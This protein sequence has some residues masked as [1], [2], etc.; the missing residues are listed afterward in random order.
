MLAN[1]LHVRHI[2][3]YFQSLL[4][5]RPWDFMLIWYGVMHI[6][7]QKWIWQGFNWQFGSQTPTLKLGDEL[8]EMLIVVKHINY[9]KLPDGACEH[10]SHLIHLQ[11][12]GWTWKI[13]SSVSCLLQICV[14]FSAVWW[15][16]RSICFWMPYVIKILEHEIVTIWNHTNFEVWMAANFTACILHFT[17]QT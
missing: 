4:Y 16:G 2:Y 14:C 8:L 7:K 5:M 1:S 15:L 17:R 13:C 6:V 11:G 3:Q 12:C 9:L 10:C